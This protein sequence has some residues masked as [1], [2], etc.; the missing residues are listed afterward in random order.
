V[1]LDAHTFFGECSDISVDGCGASFTSGIVPFCNKDDEIS[2]LFFSVENLLQ[3]EADVLVCR[4]E[5]LEDGRIQLG[6]K[7]QDLSPELKKKLQDSMAKIQ[8]LHLRNNSELP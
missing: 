4:M 8:R 1:T 3:F 7:Y 2:G 6:L 5:T